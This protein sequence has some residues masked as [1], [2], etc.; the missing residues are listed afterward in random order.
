MP[1]IESLLERLIA[2]EVEFVVVGGYAAVAHGVALL[3]QDID[4]CCPFTLPN[5]SR[6]VAALQDLHPVHRMTPG[7]LPLEIDAGNA[8]RFRNLYLATDWG[9]IDCLGEIKGV[10]T[11]DAVFE[12]S[13]P[14]RLPIG[15]CRVLGLDALIQAKEAMGQEKDWI[16]VK[17]L[18]A[19]RERLNGQ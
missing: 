10:G 9:V 15:E 17:Q 14:V 18:R 5:L 11:F 13:V 1:T 8:G 19:I 7:R 12:A 4:V 3:T 2:N 6:I 16:A